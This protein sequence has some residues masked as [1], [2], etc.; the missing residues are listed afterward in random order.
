MHAN[1]DNYTPLMLA[2][3]GGHIAVVQ[4]LL[5][6]RHKRFKILE[7]LDH[8][9]DAGQTAVSLATDYGHAGVVELLGKKEQAE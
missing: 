8:T 4:R 9:S 1:E 5:Q 3:A 7:H 6:L 2:A